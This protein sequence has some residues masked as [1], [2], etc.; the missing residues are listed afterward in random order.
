MHQEGTKETTNRDFEDQ[1]QP[2]SEMTTNGSY[3]KAIGME[4]SKRAAGTS[5]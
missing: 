2:G 5:T 4:I 3:R 1:L